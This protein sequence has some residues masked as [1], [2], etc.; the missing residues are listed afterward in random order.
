M[1][2]NSGIANLALQGGSGEG[3]GSLPTDCGVVEGRSMG[4]RVSSTKVQEEGNKRQ[5]ESLEQETSKKQ[6]IDEE[7]SVIDYQIHHENNK[8]YYQI[9]RADGTH[10]L[11]LSFI[12]LLKNFDIEDLETLW[13]LVKERFESTKPNN[14]SDDLLLNIIKIMF[15][16][17]NVEA[18]VW[19]DQ[20][21]KYGFAKVKSWKLFE[22]C[23]VYI[24]TLT[25]TQLF[26]F[27]EKKY[28]LTHFTLEQMLN[29]VRLEVEEESEMSL[30]LLR[31]LKDWILLLLMK[32]QIKV[33]L[34]NGYPCSKWKNLII[35][36]CESR[37][38][39]I[40]ISHFV[41]TRD[42]RHLDL[43]AKMISCRS[44]KGERSQVIS[45]EDVNQKLLR[46]LSSEWNTHVVVWRN[47]ADLDTMSMDDLYNNLKVYEPEVKV[48]SN[49]NSSTQNIDFVS[50]LTNSSTNGAV[51]TAQAVNTT[52]ES[53]QAEEGPI[54]ALI[55]YT[56][57]S[58]DSKIVDNSKKGLGYENYND[59][60]PPYTGNFK[61][62]KPD[63]SFTGL[64]EFVNKHVVE[65]CEA[66]SN[67]EPKIV[68]KNNDSPII[69]DW[70]SNNED[71][72]VCQPKVEKKQLGLT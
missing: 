4:E 1:P 8:P 60:P 19:R 69:E 55:N 26:L 68:K 34:S 50:S 56:S 65:N 15:E 64:D 31:D 18:N 10:K 30:E 40:L 46:S 6:R 36:S 71:E 24:I 27:V 61:P 22:S 62:L 42:Q 11:F 37:S 2:E 47:K 58:S 41:C 28:P 63:L 16:K 20:K 9:I 5:G 48:T 33:A 39:N 35:R 29:N 43:R 17:H 53:D 57:L 72:D 66:K 49:L 7:V 25:T 52:N 14:F 3:Y 70:L 45:Q 59:V 51:N 12:T 44:Y 23:G 32:I 21:G 13:K 54:Y 67:D 38:G